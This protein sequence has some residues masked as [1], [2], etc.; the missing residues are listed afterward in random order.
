M[1][2]IQKMTVMGT[3]CVSISGNLVF[4]LTANRYVS[5]IVR[6]FRKHGIEY[7]T[8][9]AITSVAENGRWSPVILIPERRKGKPL[10]LS[11]YTP[12]IVSRLEERFREGLLGHWAGWDIFAEICAQADRR[13]TIEEVGAL[14]DWILESFRHWA[15]RKVVINKDYDLE[16]RYYTNLVLIK[17]SKSTVPESVRRITAARFLGVDVNKLNHAL[18]AV[19]TNNM[20]TPYVSRFKDL[21]AYGQVVKQP[22]TILD[23]VALLCAKKDAELDEKTLKLISI[24]AITG[25]DGDAEALRSWIDNNAKAE[26]T[27]H[28]A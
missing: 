22:K 18:F 23:R 27:L 26:Q 16:T 17:M 5:S 2:M 11:R 20:G 12:E 1:G 24:L 21:C 6:A 10:T 13:F 25:L 9:K 7:K 28:I 14:Y 15:Y 19:G 3:K 4:I 8:D